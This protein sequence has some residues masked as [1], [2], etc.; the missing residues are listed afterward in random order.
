MKPS[1]TIIN[2]KKYIYI[3]FFF[4]DDIQFPIFISVVFSMEL[5]YFLLILSFPQTVIYL[6][7]WS[8]NSQVG[9]PCNLDLKR[10]M[11]DVPFIPEVLCTPLVQIPIIIRTRG[12]KARRKSQ[13]EL[14]CSCLTDSH[15]HPGH[16]LKYEL[17]AEGI[18]WGEGKGGFRDMSCL[19]DAA[20][21]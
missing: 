18:C 11:H 3:Y 12:N 21:L 14:T 15:K 8:I 2:R 19:Q 9:Y 1:Y 20:M 13:A 6:P 17:Y 5:K 10:F 4:P 16:A 7:A